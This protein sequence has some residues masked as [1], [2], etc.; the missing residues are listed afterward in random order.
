MTPRDERR[1]SPDVDERTIIALTIGF[2]A[3]V[4]VAAAVIWLDYR[5]SP[6]ANVP[7]RLADFPA[8]Q[9]ETHTG[10]AL[11]ALRASEANRHSNLRGDQNI[12][13]AIDEAMGAIAKR[14]AAAYDP[15][16][17]NGSAG[18]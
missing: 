4:V 10:Q 9:L 7:L 6:A 1:E 17:G 5:G 16:A 2:V 3:F 8:P 15:P 13:A 18:P 11:A 12:S 14:G